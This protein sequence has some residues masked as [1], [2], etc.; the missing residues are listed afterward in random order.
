MVCRAYSLPITHAAVAAATTPARVLG[1]SDR[2][3]SI[4]AG[5]D[6]DLVV[7]DDEL[8]VRVVISAGIVV[9]DHGKSL[10]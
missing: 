10:R 9:F 7:L 6:A 4:E 8:K 1:L 2:T 3:G 5:K